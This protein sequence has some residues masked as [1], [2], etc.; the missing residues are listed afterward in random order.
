MAQVIFG[1][2]LQQYTGGVREVEISATDYRALVAELCDR[3][4]ALTPDR[5]Q[6]YA[7]GLDGVVIQKPFLEK[8]KPDSEIVFM[9]RIAGG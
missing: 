9:A 6:K 5:V 3:F 1:S 7:I 2:D 4:P 8:L